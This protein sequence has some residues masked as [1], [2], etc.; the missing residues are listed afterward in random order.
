MFQRT[1]PWV[2][3]HSNRPITKVERRLYRAVP[4]LQKLV[5]GGI[6]SAREMLVFGFVKNPRL[7]PVIE[8][9]ARRHMRSQID[10]PQLL[11]QV[12]PEYTIG[13]K[14]I[15]PSNRWYRALAKPNVRPEHERR[16]GGPGAL[17]RRRRRRRARGRRDRLRHR[18]PRHRHPG[19]PPRARAR[20]QAARRHLARQPARL[21]R[22]DDRRVPE[23]VLP[24][25]PEHRARAQLD[26]LHDRVADRARHGGVGVHALARRRDDRDPAG[27][28]GAPQRGDRPPHDGHGV[29]DRL[30][31]LVPRRHRAQRDAVAGLDVA[32]P[33][34]A[35]R[36]CAPTTTRSTYASANPRGAA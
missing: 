19:R 34:P 21:L 28:A 22:L 4:A 13:C 32:L 12:T 25:R 10:D 11:A 24:A 35:P 17:G 33:P 16:P 29:D 9:I 7:M 3:P 5:R 1:A 27:G 31:E 26:G 2:M 18:L 14:R 8:R 23:P 20:R 6:Y 30:L 36:S 15:L